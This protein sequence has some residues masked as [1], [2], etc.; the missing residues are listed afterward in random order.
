MKIT[1]DTLFAALTLFATASVS[2][3]PTVETPEQQAPEAAPKVNPFRGAGNQPPSIQSN[4]G[5]SK[6]VLFFKLRDEFETKLKAEYDAIEY[7]KA[8]MV[9]SVDK[10]AYQ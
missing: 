6:D 1:L 7:E 2:A 9:R 4:S 10:V 3:L 5:T 8:T